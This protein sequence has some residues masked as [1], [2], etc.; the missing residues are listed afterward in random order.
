MKILVLGCG[1]AGLMAAQGAHDAGGDDHIT[2]ISRKVKSRLYGAQYLHRP[3]PN[4]TTEPSIRIAYSLVGHADDYRRKVYGNLWD[5]TT[6]PEDLADEHQGW[7]IRATYDLLWDAWEGVIADA[8]IDPVGFRS[9]LANEASKPDL[10]ISTVPRPILCHQGHAFGA[11]EVWAAGDSPDNG[12]DIG[13][14]YRC[15]DGLVVC[16]G[17]DSP[18]W[19]RMSRVFGQTTVEWPGDLSAVP[20]KTA[21]R[22]RKPTSTD[23]DCWSDV[24]VM[25][26]GRYGEWAKGVLSHEAYFKSFNAVTKLIGESVAASQG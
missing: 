24:P 14:M 17:E 4:F 11:T 2:I 8:D 13:R 21:A 16:N 5:G 15:P 25:F 23:C 20:V 3:I 19:Y 1:P 22:V 7:D 18:A 6:S 10:V 26:A 9:L 12:L